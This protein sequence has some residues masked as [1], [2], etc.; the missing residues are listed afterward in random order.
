MTAVHGDEGDDQ[1]GLKVHEVHDMQAGL[2]ISHRVDTAS[3][4]VGLLPVIPSPSSKPGDSIPGHDLPEEPGLRSSACAAELADATLTAQTDMLGAALK[5]P[6]A[7]DSAVAVNIRVAVGQRGIAKADAGLQQSAGETERHGVID[8]CSQE[9][10]QGLQSQLPEHHTSHLPG[11]DAGT[12]LLECSTMDR[13]PCSQ[14]LEL[15]LDQAEQA[16][17]TQAQQLELSLDSAEQVSLSQAGKADLAELHD[18]RPAGIT[19]DSAAESPSHIG[20]KAGDPAQQLTSR[21]SALPGDTAQQ[22]PAEA[23]AQANAQAYAKPH[24]QAHAQAHAEAGQLVQQLTCKS[25][26]QVRSNAQSNGQGEQQPQGMRAHIKALLR[27]QEGG[28]GGEAGREAGGCEAAQ[29]LT[30]A[31]VI[32]AQTADQE[33]PSVRL[34]HAANMCSSFCSLPGY[35]HCM[36]VSQDC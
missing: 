30:Q 1:H 35:W 16:S 27:R 9:E 36:P 13:Q 25:S 11:D 12:V 7:V 19:L 8:L 24:D 14:Q 20:S 17:P 26:G 3:A 34:Q 28:G 15:S 2:P 21:N 18:L 4:A 22:L 6:V 31:E 23:H 33:K 29:A 32:E 5:L 10:R